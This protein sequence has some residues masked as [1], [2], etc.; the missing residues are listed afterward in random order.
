MDLLHARLIS[1][2]SR[3]R[4]STRHS[5][6]T[7]RSRTSWWYLA[8]PGHLFDAVREGA[9]AILDRL[10]ELG[11]DHDGAIVVEIVDRALSEA[12]REAADRIPGLGVDAVVWQEIEQ[13]TG[14]ETRL[15]WAYLIFRTVATIIASIGV[16]LDQPILTSARW[17]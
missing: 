12:A 16:L 6:R 15:S 13:E 1:L 8:R 4:W 11:L 10:R 14:E 5:P 9:T 7:R 3:R 2:P 17:R